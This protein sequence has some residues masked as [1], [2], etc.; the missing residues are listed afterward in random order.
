[1]TAKGT[2]ITPKQDASNSCCLDRTLFTKKYIKP[3]EDFFVGRKIISDRTI[4]T[5]NR[6]RYTS[7]KLNSDQLTFDFSNS[8]LLDCNASRLK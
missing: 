5:Q 6:D 3:S 7:L 8:Q 2:V 1:M 4:N